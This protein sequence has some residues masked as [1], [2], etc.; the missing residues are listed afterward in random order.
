MV[1]FSFLTKLSRSLKTF[2]NLSLV[3]YVLSNEATIELF[4]AVPFVL[5]AGVYV[6]APPPVVA[7]VLGVVIVG[8]V[9][10]G[11]GVGVG[12]GTGVGVGVGTGVGVGVG[13]G[14]GVGVGT[15][16]GVGVGLKFV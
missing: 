12:V 2:L 9:G 8:I 15:G 11:V 1:G 10:I 4:G 14:V 7:V 3:K 16:V 13:T 6:D 5:D